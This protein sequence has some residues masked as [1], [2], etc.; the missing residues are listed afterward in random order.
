MKTKF[1]FFDKYFSRVCQECNGNG[2]WEN[3]LGCNVS[4]SYCCGGCYKTEKCEE[5]DGEGTIYDNLQERIK[6][7]K[8]YKESETDIRYFRCLCWISLDKFRRNKKPFQNL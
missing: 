5:C 1:R 6:F 2:S 4:Q 3:Y 7:R 8:Y